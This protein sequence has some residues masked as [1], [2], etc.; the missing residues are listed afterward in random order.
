MRQRFATAPPTPATIRSLGRTRPEL[1]RIASKKDATGE[2][3]CCVPPGAV[4][5]ELMPPG[6][7]VGELPGIGYA[8]DT[9]L[10]ATGVTLGG[11]PDQ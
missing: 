6:C 11:L 8:P 2:G 3:G 4:V 7:P 10:V 1:L 5:V 9:T